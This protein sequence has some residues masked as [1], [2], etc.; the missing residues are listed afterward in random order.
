MLA[1]SLVD[2]QE[3]G[4]L[5]FPNVSGVALARVIDYCRYE[6]SGDNPSLTEGAGSSEFQQYLNTVDPA[7]L[8]EL[9]S[10]PPTR[11]PICE[12]PALTNLSSFPMAQASYY[13]DVKPLV[14]LTCRT[15]AKT[16]KGRFDP[17]LQ[18]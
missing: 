2:V 1:L 18:R 17:S 10:V 7:V 3:D 6:W 16:I 9:A 12:E 14:D 8:C 11:F 4:S 13:L 5:L 15:I